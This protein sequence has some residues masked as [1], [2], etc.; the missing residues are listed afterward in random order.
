LDFLGACRTGKLERGDDAMTERVWVVTVE[1]YGP[2]PG[3]YAGWTSVHRTESGA[4]TRLRERADE[5][6]LDLAAIDS[7]DDDSGST[8][9]TSHLELED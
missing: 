4:D 9:S 6:G 7:G 5:M 3:D 1:W 8:Y 2:E